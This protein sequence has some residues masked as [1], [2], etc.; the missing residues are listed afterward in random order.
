MG[1]TAN[2]R[3]LQARRMRE[4]ESARLDAEWVAANPQAAA[5]RAAA[6]TSRVDVMAPR[7]RHGQT[8]VCGWCAGPVALRPTGRPRKW[9]SDSCRQ[10]AW[11]TNRAAVSGDTPVRVVDRQ[12]EVEVPIRVPETKLVEI[13][14]QPSG[15]QWPDVLRTLATQVD[16]AGRH[17]LYDKDLDAVT[18]A[19][20]ELIDALSRRLRRRR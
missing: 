15:A 5:I 16:G 3:L 7:R 19:A 12:I 13:T 11:A 9:C 4:K 8:L 1:K 18:Q 10:R 2:E 6:V 17:P 14:I 20:N